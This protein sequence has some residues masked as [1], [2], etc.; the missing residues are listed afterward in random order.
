[1]VW[2][3]V[4]FVC[5]YAES[6]ELHEEIRRLNTPKLRSRARVAVTTA[7]EGGYPLQ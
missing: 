1:M 7:V 3:E 4:A 5:L 2:R 6:A